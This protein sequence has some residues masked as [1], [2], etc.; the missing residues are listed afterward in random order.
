MAAL[1]WEMR[2]AYFKRCYEDP[3]PDHLNNEQRTE[4][5]EEKKRM[6]VIIARIDEC[7]TMNF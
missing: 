6:Q 2:V 1:L 4:W 7:L 3:F 5:F